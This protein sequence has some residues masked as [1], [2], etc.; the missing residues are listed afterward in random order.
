MCPS[1]FIP[2]TKCGVWKI[3]KNNS[4]RW[5]REE[6]E[7]EQVLTLSVR[8]GGLLP[9]ERDLDCIARSVQLVARVD[10]AMTLER[11]LCFSFS[12]TGSAKV[13]GY[14]FI[15]WL[16]KRL[17]GFHCHRIWTRATSIGIE[18]QKPANEKADRR[19]ATASTMRW[20]EEEE[21]KKR[22]KCQNEFALFEK[23]SRRSAIR[24]RE[25]EP[26]ILYKRKGEKK[27]EEAGDL[28]PA[29]TPKRRRRRLR[30][31]KK[32]RNII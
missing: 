32:K 23:V 12:L 1:L 15:W 13:G 24:E 28:A 18:P 17:N 27:R 22:E 30:K 25:K 2:F 3:N 8:D 11:G 29:Q 4:C 5:K 26:V 16:L 7:K 9:T 19:R 31:K 14:F 6:E 20:R 10:Y 21:A